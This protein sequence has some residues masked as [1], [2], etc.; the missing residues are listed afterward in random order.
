MNQCSDDDQSSWSLKISKQY[1]NVVESGRKMYQVLVA[2]RMRSLNIKRVKLVLYAVSKA[3]GLGNEN[4]RGSGQ[5]MP[6]KA[7][8]RF[9]A[10]AEKLKVFLKRKVCNVVGI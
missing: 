8:M 2:L 6:S 10:R 5:I 3:V 9:C 1:H 7:I 4:M